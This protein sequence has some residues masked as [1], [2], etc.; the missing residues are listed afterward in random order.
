MSRKTRLTLCPVVIYCSLLACLLLATTSHSPSSLDQSLIAILSREFTSTKV[1]TSITIMMLR[2]VLLVFL[3]SSFTATA[4]IVFPMN[5]CFDKE[6]TEQEAQAFCRSVEECGNLP[7]GSTDPCFMRC[8]DMLEEDGLDY[9]CGNMK[10]HHDLICVTPPKMMDPG[11][12]DEFDGTG[13]K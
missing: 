5:I 9:D 7:A 8:E 11:D 13:R 12:V 4:Q 1:A 6:A 10:C 2:A 3:S